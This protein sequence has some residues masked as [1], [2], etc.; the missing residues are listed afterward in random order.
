MMEVQFYQ[1]HLLNRLS[2]PTTVHVFL[3]RIRWA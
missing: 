1:H 2:P 3:L